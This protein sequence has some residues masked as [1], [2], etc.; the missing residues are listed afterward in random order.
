MTYYLIVVAI[1]GI[2]ILQIFKMQLV[3]FSFILISGLSDR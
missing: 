1:I 2:I 3:S